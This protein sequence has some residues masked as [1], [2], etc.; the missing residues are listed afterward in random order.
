[1]KG[2]RVM[3]HCYQTSDR[4]LRIVDGSMNKI[5]CNRERSRKSRRISKLGG[6]MA[7]LNRVINCGTL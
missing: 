1:L 2:E 6:E 3:H 7:V 4:V 5:S